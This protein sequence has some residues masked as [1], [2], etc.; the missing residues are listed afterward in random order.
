MASGFPVNGPYRRTA[1]ALAA[2]ALLFVLGLQLQEA[3]H[4]HGVEDGVAQCVLCKSGPGAAAVG[5]RAPL[6]PLEAGPEPPPPATVTQALTGQ[7]LPF[8]ARGPPDN[9]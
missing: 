9:S 8:Q 3:S 7:G 1:R 2:F 6:L 4:S 5:F